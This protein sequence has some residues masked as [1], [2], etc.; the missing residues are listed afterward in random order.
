MDI[1]QTEVCL[2]PSLC[3]LTLTN[4]DLQMNAYIYILTHPR[5]FRLA[6][7]TRKDFAPLDP[8]A[9]S[10]MFAKTSACST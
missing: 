8:Y 7:T 4:V 2:G 1:V 9:P 3:I 10:A 6:P 5:S